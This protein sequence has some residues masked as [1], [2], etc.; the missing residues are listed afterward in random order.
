MKYV[1]IVKTFLELPKK[2]LWLFG[3][4]GEALFFRSFRITLL[5]KLAGWGQ[6]IGRVG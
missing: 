4:V 3:V 6:R 1:W 5:E 2:L